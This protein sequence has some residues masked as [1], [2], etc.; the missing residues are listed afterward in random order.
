MGSQQLDVS[1]EEKH[2]QQGCS[3]C[4]KRITDR[5]ENVEL[6]VSESKLSLE[7]QEPVRSLLQKPLYNYRFKPATR[8]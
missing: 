1:G 6:H 4:G 5:Q 2:V 7:G 8:K 3:G